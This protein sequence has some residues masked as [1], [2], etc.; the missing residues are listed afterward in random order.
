V[1]IPVLSPEY[2]S[3]WTWICLC[4]SFG[5][6]ESWMVCGGVY[7]H[8]QRI[9]ALQIALDSCLI[10]VCVFLEA[11]FRTL[12]I[13]H[14]FTVTR[15]GMRNSRPCRE[16]GSKKL[17]HTGV[18]FPLH[19]AGSPIVRC[20]QPRFFSFP[21]VSQLLLIDPPDCFGLSIRF[22]LVQ[23]SAKILCLVS[24]PPPCI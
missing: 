13:G 22:K 5:F 16:P 3:V 2:M 12:G 17:T 14:N 8:T 15:R 24:L 20:V 7:R 4:I 23:R 18:I 11:N 1:R 19:L 21:S 9:E 10:T 6:G